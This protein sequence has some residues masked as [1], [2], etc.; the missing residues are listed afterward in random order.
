MST[1]KQ[2]SSSPP[3]DEISWWNRTRYQ[4]YAPI[5]DWVAQ[6][7]ERGRTRAIDQL[8]LTSDDRILII[9]SGPGSDLEHLP[10]NASITA[11]DAAPA[12]VRR[13]EERAD[14]LGMDVDARVGNAK[15]LPFDDG[16]FD[17]VFLHLI[18]TVVPDPKAV[19]AEAA[20]VLTPEGRISIYD[21][22]VPE[23]T[24]PSLVRRA[25]NPIARFLFSDLTYQLDPILRHAG[26][27]IVGSKTSAL[28]G[29]YTIAQAR[30][31]TAERTLNQTDSTPPTAT[32]TGA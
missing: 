28:G 26:L 9:G 10:R 3:S 16:T 24:E 30:P 6:P 29:L 1:H 4:L 25:L 20:R 5:Y 21:K 11:V 12:M 17:V 15:T 19:A 2:F 18:L 22:F 27:E 7:L 14:T 13:T 31:V 32:Q 23:G 8:S